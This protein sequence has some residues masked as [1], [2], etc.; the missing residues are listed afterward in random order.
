MTFSEA[1]GWNP[2]VHLETIRSVITGIPADPW[3]WTADTTLLFPVMP[4]PVPDPA[5]VDA[6][7][8][9]SCNRC[10]IPLSEY[11]GHWCLADGRELWRVHTGGS[12]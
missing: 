7:D 11:E 4:R 5:L 8:P 3:R 10:H 9:V 2:F 12:P 6:T 1:R